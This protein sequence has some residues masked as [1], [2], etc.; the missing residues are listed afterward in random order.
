LAEDL[1]ALVERAGRQWD[2]TVKWSQDRRA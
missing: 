2:Y 1:P